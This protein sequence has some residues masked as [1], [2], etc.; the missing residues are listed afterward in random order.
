MLPRDDERGKTAAQ[1]STQDSALSTEP[2]LGRLRWDCRRGMLELDI[3][4]ARFMEQNFERLAPQE[5][6]AF[7]ELLA[8]SDPDLWGLLQSDE[9]GVDDNATKVLT[10]LRAK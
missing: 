6:A 3:V 5:V 8:C 2:P 1:L 4:L 7:K 10:L 9:T